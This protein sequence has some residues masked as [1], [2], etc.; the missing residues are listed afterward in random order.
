MQGG[1]WAVVQTVKTASSAR[2]M[3]VDEITRKSYLPAAEMLPAAGNARP[4]AKPDSFMIIE[5][6]K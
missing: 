6:G 1:K 5:V 4:Q 2:T 3:G